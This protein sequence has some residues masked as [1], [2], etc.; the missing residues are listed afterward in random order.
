[1]IPEF[2][3]CPYAPDP[4]EESVHAFLCWQIRLL[5]S[6]LSP[7]ADREFHDAERKGESADEDEHEG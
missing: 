4:Q 2:S 3:S 1:L 6:E 5:T 7:Y